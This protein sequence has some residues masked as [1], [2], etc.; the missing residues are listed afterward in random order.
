MGA[1]TLKLH[2]GHVDE[3]VEEMHSVIQ[4]L[5]GL[6]TYGMY[7][8]PRGGVFAAMALRKI[9][10]VWIV[11][12]PE[13]ADVIVD[14]IVDTG[15]TRH[16][17]GYSNPGIPFVALVDKS[18]EGISSWVVFPWEMSLEEEGPQENI[19]RI[20]Q[21]I[22]EDPKREGLLETPDRVVRS[23]AELFAGYK[24]DP[25]DVFKTFDGDG[26]DEI[27][28]LKDIEIHSMCEHHMLPFLGRAHVAYI[29]N[30]KV[31][32]L[33]KL[34]RLVDIFARRLQIQEKLTTQVT[35]A[36]NQYLQPQG[37]AC[38]IEAKHLC[39]SCRGVQKQHSSMVTS[40]MTGVFREGAA[41]RQELLSLIHG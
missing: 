18:K 39:V 34:A 19:R 7:P 23:Y 12:K 21:Y 26:Y 9:A 31:I 29:P 22:G 38:I 28:L 40:S 1:T 27:V 37:S 25:A 4:K 20:L 16:R 5:T 8:V 11:E 15:A 3:R 14:D 36:L 10:D 24:Q 30:G 32:G 35:E 17:Y 41:A 13:E 6:D 2:W 33:S